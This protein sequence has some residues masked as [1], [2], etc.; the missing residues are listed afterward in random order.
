MSD[1]AKPLPKIDDSNR[2]FWEGLRRREVR[3]LQCGACGYLRFYPF[4]HCPRCGS[5]QGE[6]TPVSG[7]GTIWSL[8]IFHQVYFEGF[9]PEIPYNVVI[10]ELDAGPR[11]YSNIV[12]APNEAIRIGARVEP[13]FSDVTPE[14]TLLKF[15][16]SPTPASPR[17]QQ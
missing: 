6:W 14:I 1:Y 4:R 2:Q 15:R 10:V 3:F 13:V 7:T 8:G 11:L 5:E 9:R 16:L 17:E 12:D